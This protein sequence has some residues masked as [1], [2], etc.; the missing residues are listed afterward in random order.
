MPPQA[1]DGCLV[2]QYHVHLQQL[3]STLESIHFVEHRCE[4]LRII[5]IADTH[6][7]LTHLWPAANVVA[8]RVNGALQYNITG[9][10]T[11]LDDGILDAVKHEDC[12][13]P[14]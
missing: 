12:P 10:I 11:P 9:L 13:F 8:P 1:N 4:C 3:H 2:V 5:M 14:V 7:A 6:D